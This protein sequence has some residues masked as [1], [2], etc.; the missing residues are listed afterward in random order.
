MTSPRTISLGLS[1]QR[2]EDIQCKMTEQS[3]TLSHSYKQMTIYILSTD[4]NLS[5]S[6]LTQSS[7]NP[8]ALQG[9][10]GRGTWH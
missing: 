8:R 2:A 10:Q 3:Q 6:Y 9:L 4:L 7:V 5:I 1:N